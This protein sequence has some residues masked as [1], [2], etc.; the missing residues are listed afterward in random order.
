M[1]AEQATGAGVPPPALAELWDQL[2]DRFESDL[3]ANRE[4]PIESVLEAM[5]EP[6][7]RALFR[8]L[9]GLEL[10]YRGASGSQACREEYLARF[11][12]FA[13]LV[14]DAFEATIV[15]RDP[16]RFTDVDTPE[17]RLDLLSGTRSQWVD[18]IGTG[19]FR[20]MGRDRTQ[21]DRGTTAPRGDSAEATVLGPNSTKAGPDASN[22][23]RISDDLPRRF[24]VLRPHAR[25][26]LGDVFIA[27]DEDLSREVAFKRIGDHCADDR[28]S[29]ARFLAEAVITGNLEHPGVVPVYALGWYDGRPY[30]AMRLI[31]GESLQQALDRFHAD[32]A[33]AAAAGPRSL[34]LR[35]LLG[36]FVT[37]CDA[38][39]Y[40]HDRGFLHRDLKPSNIML[41]P[42][43]ETLIVDWGLAAP[44]GGDVK[45]TDANG[46]SSL[47][48]D[49]NGS[50]SVVGTPAFMSPEQS[51]GE[52]AHVGPRSDVY[53]LGATLYCMLAG[54]PPFAGPVDEVFAAVRTG[55]FPRPRALDATLDPALEAVCLKAMATNPEDRYATPRA[56]AEDIERWAADEPVSAWREPISLRA[57]RWA[58]RN[59]S[60]VSAAAA[61][62][63][64]GVIGL[65][66]VAAVQ[67]RSNAALHRANDQTRQALADTRAAQKQ[68]GAAL[69]QSEESRT[70]AE[71]VGDF[72]VDALKKP[73]PTLEGRD[74]K[75]ADVLD[76]AAAGL[77]KGFKGSKSTEGALLDALGRSY[78]GLGLR[79]QAEA[80]HRQARAVRE[81]ALGPTHRDTLRSTGRHADA[82]WWLGRRAEAEALHEATL[83]RKRKALG[84]DDLDTLESRASLAG[85]YAFSGR[86]DEAIAL[87]REVLAAR[88]AQLGSDHHDTLQTR[89]NLAF[90]CQ[91]AGRYAEAIALFEQTLKKRE[92]L[93]GLDHVEVHSTRFELARTY[94][95]AG[96]YA[97]AIASLKQTWD[98]FQAKLGR[99]H[100]YTL[101][102][103]SELAMAYRSA[104][105]F[106]EAVSLQEESLKLYEG[107]FKPDHPEAIAAR[108][109]LALAYRA[110]GR[111]AEAIPIYERALKDYEATLGPDHPETL[112][113]SNSLANAYELAGRNAEA[114]RLHERT[115]RLRQ[116]KL[117]PDHPDTLETANN[118]GYAYRTAGRSAEAIALHERALKQYEAKLG[119]DH[120]STAYSRECLAR[121]YLSTGKTVESISNYELA[122]KQRMTKLGPDHPTTLGCRHGLA[123]A[124]ES[125]RR[126]TSAETL[127]RDNVTSMRHARPIDQR[128]LGRDLAALGSNL[129]AQAKWT[130]AEPV[131]REC[132]AIRAKAPAD[133]PG[134]LEAT[135]LLGTS[136][137]GQRRYAEAEPLLV[138]SLEGLKRR[139]ASAP[140]Q[141]KDRVRSAASRL[142]QLY[143]AWGKPDKANAWK[144]K[145]G[146]ADLPANVFA[147]P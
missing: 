52:S 40:A 30:Y 89:N 131:L 130:E 41:G 139:E 29:R 4:P 147:A 16:M 10:A 145:L 65:S 48:L 11:P 47:D 141:A 72:L 118:L 86:A 50:G 28:T 84:P 32:G 85:A 73:D 128:A 42:Y 63:L 8:E 34:A 132:L 138:S 15:A 58:R 45:G 19:I 146:L 99:D 121:A 79:E 133:D 76:Q 60:V 61:A 56:L 82:L 100:P 12:N 103:R 92:A 125:V 80:M 115:L 116:A 13:D 1:R 127:L 49:E 68:T 98:R 135:N 54:R 35:K 59:R 2:C 91:R 113:A 74:V 55:S 57:R 46:R 36:R 124:Y 24:R 123:L 23:V 140:L 17:A 109:N 120:P 122:L 106:A 143:D 53:S 3:K 44:F 144:A 75:V 105:R 78:A 70:Q 27:H 14:R 137:L 22:S 95:S 104:G 51:S 110:N 112:S 81:S 119:S 39:T 129:L 142:V 31:R 126:W 83:E 97:D 77:S 71:A 102:T 93:L 108:V 6:G 101:A 94:L 69:A 5:P 43:G 134:R 111:V 18:L 117:G 21:I 20:A 26:G 66:A 90:A 62:L 64:A 7:R 33:S 37:V 88:E 9:L 96:R 25:G 136:L 107:R 38:V 67:A 87:N 114:I